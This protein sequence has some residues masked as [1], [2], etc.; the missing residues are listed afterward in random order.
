MRRSAAVRGQRADERSGDGARLSRAVADHDRD[1]R[2]GARRRRDRGRDFGRRAR[3]CSPN[4]CRRC[5]SPLPSPVPPGPWQHSRSR[6]SRGISRA[7]KPDAPVHAS[8]G[9]VVTLA[10]LFGIV[11]G[12]AVLTTIIVVYGG[13]ARAR[14]RSPRPSPPS[15][16]TL[17]TARRTNVTAREFADALVRFGP[18]AI[19]ASTLMMLCVNLY[20]AARSTQLSRNLPRPWPD[21]PTSLACPGRWALRSSPASRPPMRCPGPPPNISRS[22]PAGSAALSRCRDWRSPTR[23]R[24]ASRCGR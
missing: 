17:S 7:H 4:L 19:A 11:G 6:R 8:V 2:L 21:L 9:A 23:C 18:P 12:A 22:A 24:A 13:Y 3:R 1:A 20:A 5:C 16:P 14:A 10:A 15:P